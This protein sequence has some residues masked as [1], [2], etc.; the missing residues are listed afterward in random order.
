[1][2][3]REVFVFQMRFILVCTNFNNSSKDA[4]KVNNNLVVIIY[5]ESRYIQ[6]LL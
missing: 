1:M 5:N 2:N 3:E 4:G 6:S